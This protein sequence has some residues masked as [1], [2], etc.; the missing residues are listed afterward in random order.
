MRIFIKKTFLA[1]AFTTMSCGYSYA[2]TNVAELSK[3]LEIMSNI[4][5]TSLKQNSTK[6]GIRFRDVG[7]TYLAD[8]GVMFEISTSN[9]GEGFGL[10]FD[11]GEM[12]DG[13]QR[14]I[15]GARVPPN[16]VVFNGGRVELNLNEQD[17]E[18]Y[19][20]DA[21]DQVREVMYESRGKLRELAEQQREI[22]WEEREYE[23]RKRDLE[24]E[25]R[26]AQTD[27]RKDIDQQ[28]KELAGELQQLALKRVEVERY[29]Q[30]LEA[31]QK[32]QAEKQQQAKKQQYVQFLSGFEDSIGNVLCRYGAGI[33]TLPIDENI[34]F[35]LSNFG[36]VDS[37]NRGSKQ[38]RIYVFKYQ[39]VQACVRDK[40]SQEKLLAGVNSYMF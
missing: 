32:Q 11:L 19:V 14:I 20:E 4:L 1:F 35:V 7:V 27:R 28:L 3:E 10:N 38:D 34:S 13:A 29:S 18:V 9:R 23:R 24:F 25:K 21:M 39:D 12:F 2:M 26:S 6:Q 22:A 31:E 16:P 30:T 17:L 36:S 5:Q 40:I 8:Q 33:K 15:S 37:D